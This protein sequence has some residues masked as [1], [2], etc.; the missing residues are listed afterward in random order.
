M[1]VITTALKKH[2]PRLGGGVPEL[3]WISADVSHDSHATSAPNRC[4]RASPHMQ[5][6]SM[7]EMAH[8]VTQRHRHHRPQ[9]RPSAK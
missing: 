8:S 6:P 7:L 2:R 9:T 4:V 1:Q 5:V 3:P